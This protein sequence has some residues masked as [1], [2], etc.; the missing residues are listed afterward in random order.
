[1]ECFILN[2][3]QIAFYNLVGAALLTACIA[4]DNKEMADDMMTTSVIVALWPIWFAVRGAYILYGVARE[5][6]RR[7][8]K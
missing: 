8:R 4:R 1:M 2:F 5:F 3:S 6:L 7:R